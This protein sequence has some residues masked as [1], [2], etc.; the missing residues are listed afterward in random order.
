ML[1][2][3]L[4]IIPKVKGIVFSDFNYGVISENIIKKVT[5]IAHEKNILLFADS[6]SSSQICS[7]TKFKKQTL[8]CPNEKEARISLQNNFSGLESLVNDIFKISSPQKL[9]MK[10]GGQGFIAYEKNKNGRLQN[11]HFPA[12]S[13]NPADVAGAGDSLLAFMALSLSAGIDFMEASAI[14]CFMCMLAVESIGN[15]SISDKQ[16]LLRIKQY[17]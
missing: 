5:E 16:L 3:I 6:Q 4:K 14:S 7:I 10:L 2:H 12:L 13:S 11:Q 8:L 17:L 9:I 1:N 15:K